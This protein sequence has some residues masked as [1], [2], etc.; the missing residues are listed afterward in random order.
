MRTPEGPP[1]PGPR[2]AQQAIEALGNVAPDHVR[3]VLIPAS[4]RAVRPAHGR[5]HRAIRHTQQEQDS[6]RCVLGMVQGAVPGSS[7]HEQLDPMLVQ[8]G[9]NFVR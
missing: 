8:Q 7:S 1:R 4:H 6:G 5:H 2:Q 3:D 9:H